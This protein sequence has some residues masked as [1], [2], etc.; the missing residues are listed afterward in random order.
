MTKDELDRLNE[1][2]KELMFNRKHE[3]EICDVILE[4]IL[5]H[6]SDEAIRIHLEPLI[7]HTTI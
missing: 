5:P 2:V 7:C 1:A 3:K 4:F 6:I